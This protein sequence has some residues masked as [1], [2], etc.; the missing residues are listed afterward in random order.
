[1]TARTPLLRSLFQIATDAVTARKHELSIDA[2]LTERDRRRGDGPVVSRRQLLAGSAALAASL[3]IPRFA[4][5]K[6][7]DA[8]KNG[9]PKIVIV[10][11]GLAGLTAALHLADA[12][13]AATVYESSTRIGGRMF[14]NSGRVPGSPQYW[15]DDQVTE[16]CGEL[17]DSDHKRMFALASRFNLP[18]DDLTS[19]DPPGIE[20]VYRF[21]DRY[22]P[23]ADAARDFAEKLWPHFKAEL[24]AMGKDTPTFLDGRSGRS[25]RSGVPDKSIRRVLEL[26][27]MSVRDWLQQIGIFDTHLGQLVDVAYTIEYGVETTDQSALDLIEEMG[28]QTKPQDFSMFGAS[29]ERYHIRGGNQLLPV[30]IASYLASLFRPVQMGNRLTRIARNG[31]GKY[32]LKFDGPAGTINDADYVILAIPFA[33][34]RTIDFSAAEFDELKT[35]AIR[36]QGTGRNSKLQLQFTKPLWNER[37]PWGI[38]SGTTYSDTG[39][40]CSWSPSRGQRVPSTGKPGTH[41]IIN[42]YRGGAATM[43]MGS[44][45]FAK[46]V[47]E[48][49][50]LFLG[51]FEP[52]FP[53]VSKL[54]TGKA[55]ISIPHLDPNF[56]TAYSYYRVGQVTKF[57]GYEKMRQKNCLFAGEHTSVEFGGFM[58]GAAESGER[59]AKEI[60]LDLHKH[61]ATPGAVGSVPR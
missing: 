61:V 18:I 36:E 27:N 31:N 39:Y 51:Q 49:P 37:G 48:Q 40:Q 34:L 6:E 42:N 55:T 20:E 11:G 17:L 14:S 33:V 3:A 19:T 58:E 38:G 28:A 30:S 13:L 10:G 59:A 32:T 22:Y 4:R 53:G 1:M 26:D 16:W 52:V 57:C 56:K 50:R 47:V 43:A 8:K 35:T 29:N 60:L 23:R 46:D 2:L 54:W 45:A 7:S 44:V 21:R 12:G 15:F 41:A 24:K 25:R 5:A 9:D